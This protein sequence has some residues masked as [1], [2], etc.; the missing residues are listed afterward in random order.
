MN[1][2]VMLFMSVAAALLLSSFVEGRERRKKNNDKNGD[3]SSGTIEF[4]LE[5]AGELKISP[6]QA[7]ALNDLKDVEK[8]VMA[9]PAVSGIMQKVKEAKRSGNQQ[10]LAEQ[11]ERLSEKIK[12]RTNGKYGVLKEEL[13]KILSPEQQTAFSEM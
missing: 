13:N 8:T 10:A 2:R 3:N 6:T 9:D 11:K 12:E 4:I 5:H 7:T 1:S